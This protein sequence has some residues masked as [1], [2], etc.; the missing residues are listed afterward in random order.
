RQL[1]AIPAG[2]GKLLALDAQKGGSL[3]AVGGSEGVVELIDVKTG[4]VAGTIPSLPGIRSL[5][6]SPD[7]ERLAVGLTSPKADEGGMAEARVYDLKGKQLTAFG[8]HRMWLNSVAFSPDGRLLVT[9]GWPDFPKDEKE[10]RRSE[11][12]KLMRPLV[13]VWDAATGKLVR[14]L[15]G[16]TNLTN[17]AVF[18]PDGKR[19]LTTSQDSTARVW[20]VQTGQ[21]V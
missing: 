3:V 13:K 1:H 14:A 15:E 5:A 11:G 9:T 16:H 10:L 7:G 8:A 19:I 20:D 17:Y 2:K 4:K 18:S 21:E 12:D 6:F